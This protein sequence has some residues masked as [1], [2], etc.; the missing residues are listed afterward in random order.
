MNFFFSL[1]SRYFRS[2]LIVPK[3]K[4]RK[5]ISKNLL[6]FKAQIKNKLWQIKK[7]NCVNKNFFF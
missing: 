6:L 1:K 3:F 7:V 2:D 4:N 5:P